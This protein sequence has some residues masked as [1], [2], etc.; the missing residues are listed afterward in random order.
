[1]VISKSISQFE[2]KTKSPSTDSSSIMTSEL[3]AG[4]MALFIV[5]CFYS[6]KLYLGQHWQARALASAGLLKLV[7]YTKMVALKKEF[8][9][10]LSK[11]ALFTL[12]L[13]V[14]FIFTLTRSVL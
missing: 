3:H 4:Q 11:T 1:M 14:A 8:F 9:D 10:E 2:Q 7:I 13:I 12:F 5:A 6:Q